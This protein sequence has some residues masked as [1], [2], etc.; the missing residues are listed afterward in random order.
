MLVYSVQFAA[1]VDVAILFTECPSRLE[2]LFA[3]CPS[4]LHYDFDSGSCVSQCPC[5]FIGFDYHTPHY[6]EPGINKEKTCLVHIV[7]FFTNYDYIFIFM[8]YLVL[9]VVKKHNFRCK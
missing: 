9:V 8:N 6:C 4:H 5:G 7:I 2:I 3:D 1:Q